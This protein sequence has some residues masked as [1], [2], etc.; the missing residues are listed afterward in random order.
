MIR[1]A[2]D[3]VKWNRTKAARLLKISYRTLLYKIG[4]YGLTRLPSEDTELFV[5]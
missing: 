2:L 1:D 5:A 4:G 3:R